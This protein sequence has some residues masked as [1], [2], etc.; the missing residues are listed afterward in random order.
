MAL[1]AELTGQ[2]VLVAMKRF[3]FDD[4]TSGETTAL[5]TLPPGTVRL[6][7]SLVIET[8]FNSGTS[9]TIDIGDAGAQD[10]LLSNNDGSA[11]GAAL[12]GFADEVQ[13]TSEA[14]TINWTGAG[15]APTTGAGYVVVEY[16]IDG[17]S[18]EN[19]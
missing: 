15:D 13:S 10:A 14:I 1:T 7:G 11:G 5:F 19:L 2:T 9:D 16:V 6:R 17:R 12:T 18:V 3:T 4:L 8:A